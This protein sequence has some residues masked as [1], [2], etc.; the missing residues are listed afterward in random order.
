M[1]IYKHLNLQRKYLY[2]AQ[3]ITVSTA[4]ES[5]VVGQMTVQGD[6]ILRL[7]MINAAAMLHTHGT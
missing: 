4:P 6:N 7:Q 5:L 3:V 2:L 1:H